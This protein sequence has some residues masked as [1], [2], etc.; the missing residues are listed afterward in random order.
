MAT[1]KGPSSSMIV[2]IVT[3]LSTKKVA[4]F[5]EKSFSPFGVMLEKL[6]GP[7]FCY[8]DFE[9]NFCM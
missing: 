7:Y 8:G 1:W 9:H 3:H 2:Q 6:L 5:E 4:V